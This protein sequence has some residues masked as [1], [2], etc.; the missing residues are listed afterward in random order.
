MR[1]LTLLF[2]LTA[3]VAQAQAP[4]WQTAVSA[5][6]QGN[7]PRSRAFSVATDE[8]GN[9]YVAGSFDRSIRLGSI[10]LTSNGFSDVF[11]AKWSRASGSFVWAQQAGGS[12]EDEA[13]AIAVQGT[14]VY[15]AGNFQSTT[16]SFGLTT[17]TNASGD[18]FGSDIFVAK[19]T[20]AGAT[21]GFAWAQSAGGTGSDVVTA[22]AV[23]GARV[24]VAGSF[25]SLDASFG[26]STLTTA[27][28]LDG[29]V[30]QLTDLGSTGSFTWTQQ[31]SG[32]GLEGVNALAVRG[33][34]V[35]AAGYFSSASARLG[36]FELPNAGSGSNDLFVAKLTD[37]TASTRT[38]AASSPGV[39]WVQ[40][41]GGPSSEF[42]FAV[43]VQG[44]SVYL[45]GSFSGATTNLGRITL[46]NASPTGTSDAFI[47]KLTDATTS[48]SFMWAQRAGGTG[49]DGARALTTN[50]SN[51]YM[52]GDFD[53]ATAGFGSTTLTNTNPSYGS[54][55]NL[56][57]AKLT[58]A[59]STGAFAWSQQAGTS[60]GDDRAQ[61]LALHGAT[62]YVTGYFAGLTARFGSLTLA[63][64]SSSPVAYL[65][66]LTDASV[67][68]NS[69]P[70]QPQELE[71]YPNPA[72]TST[73]LR[74]PRALALRSAS[75]VQVHNTLGQ[76][77]RT[78]FIAP[79]FGEALLDV[80][81]LAS[82]VYLLQVPTTA[83]FV[84]QRLVVD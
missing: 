29:F 52:A 42:V 14:S 51:V 21:G 50:G 8:Q 82:G 48:A 38:P 1:L 84:S 71:L 4:T 66:S 36:G 9:A 47:A 19:L 40:R 67:L 12:A 72:H 53:S 49:N 32:P 46:S 44:A 39:A 74:I 13:I 16:A 24:Y 26:S 77:V 11:V 15:V 31:V 81:G 80:S 6:S 79:G 18:N 73:S 70:S 75:Q 20:D 59:G 65:A 25:S 57:V 10:S 7:S 34:D 68:A 60:E 5:I 28:S 17:L 41:A 58:D 55:R 3:A 37:A 30:A 69:A 54:Y 33:P 35:Y 56:F 61:S 43:A 23:S 27:G 83:G 63:G 76:V 45:A 78:S 22:L 2:V 64:Q 62:V